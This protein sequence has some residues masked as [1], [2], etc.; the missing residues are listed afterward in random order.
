MTPYGTQ[1]NPYENPFDYDAPLSAFLMD[2]MVHYD[3]MM[4]HGSTV[5][6]A[7]LQS[8]GYNVKQHVAEKIIST[9]RN[10]DLCEF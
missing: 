3:M 8:F 5:E 6:Y 9:I 1:Y 10:K 4:A 7:F 2:N